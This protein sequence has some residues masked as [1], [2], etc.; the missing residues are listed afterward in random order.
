MKLYDFE[1]SGNCYKIRLFLSLLGLDYERESVALGS[2]NKTPEFRALNPLGLVPVLQDGEAVLWDSQAIL[3][4]LARRYDSSGQWL[5][6][7]ASALAQ[8]TA[9]LSLASNEIGAGPASVR[10]IHRFGRQEDETAGRALCE[11]VFGILETH[12]AMHHWLVGERPTIADLACYPYLALAPEGKF[13]TSGY[14]AVQRWFARIEA[15]PGYLALTPVSCP[16]AAG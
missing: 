4:Y 3:V 8:V 16:I 11:K 2:Q 10:R 6:L 5:P 14:A 1:L 13:E 12:L 7:E 9:W 15:L